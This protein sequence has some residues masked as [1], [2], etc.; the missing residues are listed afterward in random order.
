MTYRRL[1]RTWSNGYAHNMGKIKK[2]FPELSEI[3][4]EE[5][6]DRFIELGM[7]FYVEEKQGVKTWVRFTLPFAVTAMLIMLILI[8]VVFLV[9]GKWGYSLSNNNYILNWFRML[10]LL[11]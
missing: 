4:S 1:K 8:P 5:M 6:A 10:H 3:D 9:T 7:D 2:V 11:S